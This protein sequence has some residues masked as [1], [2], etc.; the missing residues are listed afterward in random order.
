MCIFLSGLLWQNK[1]NNV[2]EGKRKCRLGLIGKRA[3]DCSNYK[4]AWEDLF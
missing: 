3:L 2:T 4:Q 1:Q